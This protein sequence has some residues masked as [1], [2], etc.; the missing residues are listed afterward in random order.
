MTEVKN[1]VLPGF[2][3]DPS[4]LRAGKDYYI[5]T[6]TF[7]WFPGV[8]IY[9]SK[10]MANWET[11]SYGLTDEA[12]LN[13]MGMDSACGIWAPNLTFEDGV[14]YL[15]YTIVYTNRHRF[16]DTH[17]FLVTAKDVRGP[18][19]RPVALNRTGFDPSLFHDPSGKKWLVNML[20]DYRLDHVRFGGVGIQEYN[21]AAKRLTGP[22]YTVF[23]GSEA[24]TTEGPNIFFHEGYYYL[25]TAEGGTEF[26]HCVTMCRAKEV[27][28]PYEPCPYNPILTSFGKAEVLLK[29]AGHGQII[30]DG[31]GNWYMAHLCSRTLDDCSILGRES[32]IQNMTLTEDGWFKVS[33]NEDAS[34]EEVF[35]IPEHVEKRP[36]K[37]G[38][39]DFSK[40]PVPLE[41]MTL[42]QS[43][44]TCGIKVTEEKLWLTGGNSL[45]SKYNQAFLARRQQ[46]FS[47]DFT[48]NMEFEPLSYRHMAGVACYY[49]Y[50]NYYYVFVSCGE[51]GRRFVEVLSSV[52][53]EL[54]ESSRIYLN[55]DSSVIYLRAGVRGRDLQF[56][57]SLDGVRYLEAGPV[58][59]M[60][61]LSDERIF[62]NGFTGAM[63]GVCCQDLLGDGKSAGFGWL[64][65]KPV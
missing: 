43:M 24:G 33:K 63:V 39:V 13:L 40:D 49:N 23:K 18:W 9:H 36:E 31:A 1:P 8:C 65:Y 26:N 17:N 15:I 32:A 62:G 57:Y 10:D 11:V 5:A 7:E 44:E 61:N 21:P 28:G 45:A 58:L 20:F 60:R 22:V 56:Y 12:D 51:D 2:N 46:H 54:Q 34:P 38:F 52:N 29:R 19:S 27:T 42:R 47:Y 37:C 16:K 35:T 4:L 64:E 53:K 14:F 48:A 25:V 30:E 50:D 59:D 41:Y 55:G 6:S 3:P